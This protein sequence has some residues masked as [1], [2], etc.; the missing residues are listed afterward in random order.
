[1]EKETCTSLGLPI[2]PPLTSWKGQIFGAERGP[3][4]GS[5]CPREFE[6]RQLEGAVSSSPSGEELEDFSWAGLSEIRTSGWAC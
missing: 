4:Y 5:K 1:M 3:G 2:R 6:D